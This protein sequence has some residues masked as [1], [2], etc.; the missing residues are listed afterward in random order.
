MGL[1]RRAPDK[2]PVPSKGKFLFT[3]ANGRAW[4]AFP[5]RLGAGGL[6]RVA[7]VRVWQIRSRK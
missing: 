6:L 5:M 7:G 2:D 4:V 1:T 3:P